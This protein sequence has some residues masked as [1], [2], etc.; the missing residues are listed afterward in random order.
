MALPALQ[1]VQT[2][3]ALPSG[4]WRGHELGAA[5]ALGVSTGWHALDAELP[6]GGWP[7]AALSEI[8]MPQPS[9]VEWRIVG[10]AVRA[11]VAQKRQVVLIAPPKHPHLPG[12]L[13]EGLDQRHLVWIKAEAPADRLWVA[14]QLIK[15]NAAGAVLAWLPQARQ[16]QI[17][18]LQIHAQGGE[19]LC[20]LFRPEAAQ[21][22][23]SAAPLRVHVSHSLDWALQVS[24]LKRRGPTYDGVLSLPSVPGGLSAIIT[25]RLARPSRLLPVRE[26]FHVVG[27]VAPRPAATF[28]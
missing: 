23:S 28:H 9:T 20:F 12:L 13:H 17:R 18:R 15:S 14:E 6:G 2:E 16:E 26:S 24:I 7:T 21:H 5:S 4:V 8:L 27:S 10:P 22:E 19:G 25:P 1:L 3:D 11:I